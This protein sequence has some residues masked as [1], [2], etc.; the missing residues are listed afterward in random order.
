MT[1]YWVQA[2]SYVLGLR[3][4]YLV[5]H[6]Y[7]DYE[8]SGHLEGKTSLVVSCALPTLPTHSQITKI[9]KIETKNSEPTGILYTLTRLLPGFPG[10]GSALAG[11]IKWISTP[12]IGYNRN[13]PNKAGNPTWGRGH[14]LP[15]VSFLKYSSSVRTRALFF[16]FFEF[17]LKWNWSHSVVSD[18]L[19]PRGL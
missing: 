4:N 7:D 3:H 12:P 11:A 17:S 9:F 10:T 2:T 19:W 14:S 8:A 16:F 18:S 15:S 5:W 1:A 13:F 6:G